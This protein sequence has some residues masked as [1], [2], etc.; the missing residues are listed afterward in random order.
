MG[1]GVDGLKG[2]GCSVC[3]GCP[4]GGGARDQGSGWRDSKLLSSGE[5]IG[6]VQFSP[7]AALAP[8]QCWDLY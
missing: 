4:S 8:A 2:A 1:S 5:G 3:K 7:R 6:K